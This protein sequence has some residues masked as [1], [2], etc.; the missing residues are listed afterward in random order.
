LQYLGI[1]L[2]DHP[3]LIEELITTV[4]QQVQQEGSIYS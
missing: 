1:P 4:Q 2:S 3:E